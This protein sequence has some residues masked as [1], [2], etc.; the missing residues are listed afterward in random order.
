MI[1]SLGSLL[2]CCMVPSSNKFIIKELDRNVRVFL[3]L[4][5]RVHK[6]MRTVN[7]KPIWS[8]SYSYA[9]LM[10]LPKV[11]EKYGSLRNLWE[12][13]LSGEGIIRYVKPHVHRFTKCWHT[14]L[15]EDVLQEKSTSEIIFKMTKE[16]ARFT[17]LLNYCTYGSLE[18]IQNAMISALTPISVVVNALGEVYCVIDKASVREIKIKQY[19][20]E[21]FG[22]E[23]FVVEN[24]NVVRKANIDELD[25]KH[26]ALLFPLI[27][28]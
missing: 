20:A 25:I 12:G 22:L 15:A 2:S 17:K 4:L 14:K 1:I 3:S 9:C 11:M 7:E 16:S 23:Y 26:Y 21:C 24:T 19:V 28:I 27:M 18:I 8:T 5:E 10:N 13:S 6:S